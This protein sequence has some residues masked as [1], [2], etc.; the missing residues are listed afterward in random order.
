M[1]TYKSL[2]DLIGYTVD[3]QADEFEEDEPAPYSH[4]EEVNILITMYI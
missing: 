1:C 3:C 2:K 4:K